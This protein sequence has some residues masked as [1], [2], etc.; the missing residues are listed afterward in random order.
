MLVWV[1]MVARIELVG[2][3]GLVRWV[4][5][6]GWASELQVVPLVEV[7]VAKT[8]LDWARSFLTK[9]SIDVCH[10]L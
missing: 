8:P 5:M 1:G 6:L 7:L 2:L 3:V 9:Y 10:L 4:G